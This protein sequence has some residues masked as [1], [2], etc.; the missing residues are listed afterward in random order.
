MA[1]YS[2]KITW[3][4]WSSKVSHYVLEAGK[5]VITVAN[6]DNIVHRTNQCILI[7][8]PNISHV[9]YAAMRGKIEITAFV[10]PLFLAGGLRI[11]KKNLDEL[12]VTDG[13]GTEKFA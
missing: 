7:I 12:R 6:L 2:D 5:Y 9:S 10:G 3:G 13:D 11:N 4:Y 1:K 8:E